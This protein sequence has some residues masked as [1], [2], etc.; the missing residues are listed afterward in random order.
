MRFFIF[1]SCLFTPTLFCLAQLQTGL[2]FHK[3]PDELLQGAEVERFFV[4]RDG[5]LWFGTNKG[6]ASFDGS[7]MMYYGNKGLNG[8]TNYRIGDLAEDVPGN[9]WVLSPEYGLLFFNRKTGIFKNIDIAI[10]REAKS[11]QIEFS[12]I[13][14]DAQGVTW[15]GSW[16]R[17]FFMY[18]PKT[19]A[20]AHFNLQQGK[21]V[22]W[23]SRYE[24]SVRNIIEDKSNSNILWLACYGSGIYSFNKKTKQLQKNFRPAIAKDSSVPSNNITALIQVNDSI[25]WFSTW[26]HGM[27]VYNIKT[28]LYNTY[29]RNSSYR[30]D[31]YGNGHVLEYIAHKSDSEFYVAPRDT[32]PA[33]FNTLTKQFHFINDAELDKEYQRTQN[34]KTSPGN[35]VFYEK[36][37]G[38]FL[39]SPR[40]NLF[41][42]I[43]LEKKN[44]IYPE[45]RSMLWDERE[46]KYYAGVLLGDGVYVYDKNFLFEKKLNMPPYTGN[47]IPHTT[48]IWKLHRDKTGNLWALGYI[49]SIYDS[50]SK[51]FIPVTKKWNHLKLLDTVLFDVIEDSNGLMYFNTN[52]NEIIRYNPFTL[53]AEKISIPRTNNRTAYPVT[54]HKVS[55][56]S[57]RQYLYFTNNNRLYQYHINK[58]IFRELNFDSSFINGQVISTEGSYTIDKNGWIWITTPKHNLW[59]IDPEQFK[60]IDTIKFINSQIDL[61]GARFYGC[62]KDYLLISTLKSQL[63]FNTKTNECIYLNRSNGLLLNQGSKE[64]LCNNIMF[65]TYSGAGSTQFAPVETLLHPSKNIV[66]YISLL[67][68]NNKPA[69]IDTLPQYLSQLSLDYKHNTISIGFSA[70]D[71]DFP[72]R[73]EY[74]YKLENADLGWTYTN[75]FIKQI[76]YSDLQPGKYIFRVK[77]REWGIAWSPETTLVIRITPPFWKT[78]WFIFLCITVFISITFLLVQWRINYIRKQEQ[79]KSKHEREMMEL[80]AKA[81]RAQMNPHF[82]F[83]CMNSIKSLIQKNEQEKSIIYLTTFSKL[84]RTVFQ[85]SNKREI[86]LY[87]EIETCRL[88]TELEKLRFGNKINYSFDIDNTID[89][90]S[91]MVPALIIQPYIENAVWHGIM[92]KEAGGTMTISIKKS[93]NKIECR[94]EDDGIG[95]ETSKQN[96]FSNP[97]ARH[98][99][100]G[101][102]LTQARL[103][104]DN[105]LNERNAKIEITDKK[106][107][108]GNPTG[109]LVI[110]SF[111]EYSL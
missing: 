80:E 88:Y 102:H 30:V 53:H 2:R 82:I 58:K 12:K 24:N 8:P 76:N 44:F 36:G 104:L 50:A 90:K 55:F 111:D 37:G 33:I 32:I 105:V 20:S 108:Y 39:S 22:D 52:Q 73:L 49:T 26:G 34:V 3:I 45:I 61:N 64:M 28:G 99:S 87:D 86:S 38:L 60:V 69:A 51:Q 4:T 56:D 101:E 92:P 59:K 10:N 29:N 110:I 9:L 100:K 70:K 43:S 84:I 57:A 17:G 15:L 71:L 85:N 48:S 75:R 1:F 14:I 11:P 66:P 97:G 78:W 35:I 5:C 81:L 47:G 6:L 103:D 74:A 62:Y 91:I 23:Q 42:N 77:V 16:N 93:N 72:D 79:L 89:L 68:V 96:K 18:N 21:A 7:E 31:V 25:I 106:D 94:I 67:M 27:C 54:N 46:Q 109:T 95:R 65:I 40:F 83:N 63:L 98:E 41:Q 13:L 107:A 19:N